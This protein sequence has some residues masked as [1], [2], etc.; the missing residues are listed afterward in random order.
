MRNA[1]I[2]Y[3]DIAYEIGPIARNFNV[4]MLNF[5]FVMQAISVSTYCYQFELYLQKIDLAARLLTTQDCI[6]RKPNFD[7][8]LTVFVSLN[9]SRYESI[10]DRK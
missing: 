3:R 4:H 1:A 10:A 5:S 2:V 7:F 6:N 8:L 9:Q